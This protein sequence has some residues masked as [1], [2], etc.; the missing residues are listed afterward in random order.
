ML[1]GRNDG[2]GAADGNYVTS[3]GAPLEE[4]PVAWRL[5]LYGGLVGL[6]HVQGVA[7]F[8]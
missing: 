1:N 4:P 7:T 3:S 6:D 5:Q 8:D 2:N